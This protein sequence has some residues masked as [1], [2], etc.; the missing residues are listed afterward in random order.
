[1]SANCLFAQLQQP[2]QQSRHEFSV[3]LGGGLSSLQFDLSRGNHTPG[4]GGLAG[5]DY[6][7]F[8]NYHWSVGAGVELALLNAQATFPLFEDTYTFT[9]NGQADGTANRYSVE[10]SG[11]NYRESQEA[12]YLQIPLQVRY[13]QDFWKGHKWY[14]AIGPK[15]G[16]PLESRYTSR[17]ALESKG[18]ELSDNGNSLNMDIY[19]QIPGSGFEAYPETSPSG[20][21]D[22]G[23]HITGSLEA[24][25]KWK[26]AADWSLYS[27]LYFDYGFNNL[28]RGSAENRVFDYNRLS[29]S[30]CPYE[31]HSVLSSVHT[32][33]G[34]TDRLYTE[35]VNTLAFGVKVLVS[36]GK[37]PFDK[38]AKAAK[39]PPPEA[40]YKGLT[41]AQMEE[42]MKRNTAALLEEQHKEFE[43]LKKLIEQDDPDLTGPIYGF[44]FDKD[45]ILNLM[46]PELNRKVD[47]LKK[48]PQANILLEGHTDDSGNDEYNYRLGLERAT[49]VKTYLVHHGIASH[50]L[51]IGSKGKT[52]PALPNADESAR[53][54]NRRVEF[55]LQK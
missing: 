37:N 17:G 4:W 55:I 26:L 6:H 43:A 25:V 40:P 3:A 22:L 53:R 35:R 54:Y 19:T 9:D 20:G 10:V 38:K 15:L 18:W 33:G 31:F 46:H 36:F 11:R 13:Q 41:A 44:D 42:I 27:G 47:L 16:I 50:R 45:H 14:A 48:Y 34:Q 5:L 29:T 49:A 8:W 24:G 1:M 51:S 32:S 52:E 30:P 7:Y 23:V 2:S 12:Y 21:L 28:R 39:L